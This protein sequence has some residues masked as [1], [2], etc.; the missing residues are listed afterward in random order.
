MP[1]LLTTVPAQPPP[2]PHGTAKRLLPLADLFMVVLLSRPARGTLA[3]TWVTKATL[4]LA[5]GGLVGAVVL[6]SAVLTGLGH[7]PSGLVALALAGCAAFATGAA[8]VIAVG[9]DQRRQEP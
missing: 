1:K 2:A 4:L 9:L 3:S 8:S 5:A 6:A 7:W